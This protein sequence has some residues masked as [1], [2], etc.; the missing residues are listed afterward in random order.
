[1]TIRILMVTDFVQFFFIFKI[2]DSFNLLIWKVLALILLNGLRMIYSQ[3]THTSYYKMA[4]VDTDAAGDRSILTKY[5]I[6]KLL[7]LYNL[8]KFMNST[9]VFNFF[10]LINLLSR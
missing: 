3:I 6:S 9:I 1:M 10:I 4:A 7:I 5:K 2:S 8:I